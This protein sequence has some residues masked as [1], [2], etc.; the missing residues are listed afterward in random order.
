[1]VVVVVVVVLDV[2]VVVVVVDEL[3]EELVEELEKVLGKALGKAEEIALE[4]VP[5]GV[6]DELVAELVK[7]G[8]VSE[9]DEVETSNA[10][11]DTTS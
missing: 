3:E 5:L 4:E 9:E 7:G 11:V 2:E 8:R 1:V 10:V 6:M